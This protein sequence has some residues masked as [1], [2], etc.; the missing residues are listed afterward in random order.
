MLGSHPNWALHVNLSKL[1]YLYMLVFVQ[2]AW[3]SRRVLKL[4]IYTQDPFIPD[5][6]E[7]NF[8]DL[9]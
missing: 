6:K 9:Y 4:G 1:L 3:G 5:S 2:D 7:S 8:G